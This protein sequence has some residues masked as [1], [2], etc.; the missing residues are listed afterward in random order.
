MTEAHINLQDDWAIIEHTLHQE[1]Q[2]QR[3]SRLASKKNCQNLVSGLDWTT[4]KKA[5][6]VLSKQNNSNT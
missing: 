1:A 5:A 4:A 2:Q 3:T 6:K